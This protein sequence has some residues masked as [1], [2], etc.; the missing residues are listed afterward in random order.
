MY[1]NTELNINFTLNF[2]SNIFNKGINAT[3]PWGINTFLEH[4]KNTNLNIEYCQIIVPYCE[5]FNLKMLIMHR[6]RNIF[7][8]E[9]GPSDT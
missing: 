2:F 6:P 4:C 3:K 5:D 7:T 8:G 1:Q 9:G